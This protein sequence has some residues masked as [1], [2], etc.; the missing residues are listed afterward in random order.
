[1]GTSAARSAEANTRKVR[2]QRSL[3]LPPAGNSAYDAAMKSTALLLLILLVGCGEKAA[4]QTTTTAPK[5]E[6]PPPPSVA[7]AQ[8]LLANSPEFS[9]FQFTRA[10][11][12]LP[13]QQ[14]AMNEPARAVARD[15]RKAGWISID[16]GGTVVLTQKAA[17]DKRFLVRPNGVVDI[18]PLARKEIVA[19]DA[20]AK[21]ESGAPVADFRWRWIPN[22][23]GEVFADTYAG[24]QKARATLIAYGSDWGVLR[25]VPVEMTAQP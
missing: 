19:V 12:T 22:E 4:V 6:G 15:L 9:E 24:E 1:M 8:T 25:I 14:S 20:V 16:G 17:T 11:Y 21:D 2:S 3:T 18:V 10:A 7:E 23:I 5:P 13:M